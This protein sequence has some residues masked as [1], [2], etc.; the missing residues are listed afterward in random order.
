M[1]T[2]ITHDVDAR[3]VA[4]REARLRRRAGRDGLVLRK[5]RRRDSHARWDIDDWGGY[6]IV[7][8]ATSFV[9]AGSRFDFDLDDIE[10]WLEN[11]K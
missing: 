8:E 11:Y 4:A 9:V 1:D 2:H 5:S 10:A 3:A 7:D 6:M